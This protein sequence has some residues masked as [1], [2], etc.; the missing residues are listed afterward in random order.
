MK[1]ISLRRVDKND[2]DFILSLRNNE[3]TRDNFYTKNIIKKQDHYKYLEDQ[4][5]NQNFFNWIISYE[6]VNAGYIRILENDVSIMIDDKFQNKGIG[7]TALNLVEKEAK[8]L[9]IKKLVGRIMVHNN[10]SKKIFE[11]NNYNLLMY[12]LEKHIS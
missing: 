12:W 11:K 2:W 4:E 6:N 10:Q 1:Q 5:K 9:G 7:T 3:K 8:L